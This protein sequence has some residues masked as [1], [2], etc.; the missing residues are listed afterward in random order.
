MKHPALIA[1]MASCFLWGCKDPEWSQFGGDRVNAAGAHQLIDDAN[2]EQF[3]D[4]RL[5]T[6]IAGSASNPTKTYPLDTAVKEFGPQKDTNP[7]AVDQMQWRSQRNEIQGMLL[8]A[9]AQRCNV[10]KTY[11]R[12]LSSNEEFFTGSLATALAGVGAIVTGA[13][14]TRIFSGTAGIVSGVR[15]E[16][17][18][19]IM[20][21]VATS[22]IIPGIEKRRSEIMTEI[23]NHQCSGVTSYS[24]TM[25]LTDAIRFHGACNID[26]GISEASQSIN[27]TGN[28]EVGIDELNTELQKYSLIKKTIDAGKDV[29]SQKG[30]ATPPTDAP[31]AGA[32]A[33]PPAN[34]QQPNKL[35][36]GESIPVVNCA[37]LDGNGLLVSDKPANAA[38]AP[39]PA[40]TKEKAPA[41]PK[42]PA[43]A[44]SIST[45]R[46]AA[47]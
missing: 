30:G 36:M 42:K 47:L 45:H 7:N 44:A 14:A 16:F 40:D 8:A 5:A 9:S 26:I 32:G 37:A 38:S 27:Q 29:S 15:A 41:K 11:L 19:D 34:T 4:Q 3:S 43:K 28:N 1:A 2:F 25:A 22:V 33:T 21:N 39:A 23:A 10:F 35:T 6:L 24:L 17:Q 12:R 18:Q 20:S 31:G 13:E 46:Y